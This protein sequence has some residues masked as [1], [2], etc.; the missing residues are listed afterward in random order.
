VD[1]HLLTFSAHAIEIELESNGN[2]F[3]DKI[4]NFKDA[5]NRLCKQAEALNI[6]KSITHRDLKYLKDTGF[7][8]NYD[9]EIFLKKGF[10]YWIWKPYIVYEKLKEL[11]KNDILIYMDAGCEIYYKNLNK[12]LK[13][14]N[15]YLQI[16]EY[17]EEMKNQ[18]IKNQFLTTN[19]MINEESYTKKDVIVQLNVQNRKDILETF[20]KQSGIFICIKND[21]VESIIQK[22]YEIS[23]DYNMI[24]D[25]TNIL[26]NSSK[27]LGN[28]H[29]QSILSILLKLNNLN[30]YEN[31]P[32]ILNKVFFYD[33]N[34]T[35]K[36]VI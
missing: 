19:W 5:A 10:G 12:N 29:D 6:F 16:D 15:V 31:L 34:R 35:G 4:N 33:R 21:L 17:I 20:Q 18:V 7:F 27:F 24:N 9:K 26:K 13:I 30:T 2:C 1:I 32:K 3:Y 23:K 8:Y 11:N 14:D 28:R 22:W 25:E 36:S